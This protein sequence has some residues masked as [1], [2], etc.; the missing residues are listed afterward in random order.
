MSKRVKVNFQT[1][2]QGKCEIIPWEK[3]RETNK[4]VKKAIRKLRGKFK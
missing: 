3:I 2:N 1:I 4:R